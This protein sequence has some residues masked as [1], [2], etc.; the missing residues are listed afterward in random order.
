MRETL[1]IL[2]ASARAAAQSARRAG[3]AP[4]CGDLFADID[5]R[6]CAQATS[7]ADF[8]SE[9][10]AVARAAPQGAWMYTGG[11]ENYP[12]LVERIAAARPLWGNSA[13]VLRRVRDPFLTTET[14]RSAGLDV[15][16][17][18]LTAS[19]LFP[20]GVRRSPH[21][22]DEAGRPPELWL[23]KGRRSSGGNQVQF[24]RASDE[25]ASDER[26]SYY[27]KWIEGKSC[28]A[29]YIAAGGEA[30]LVGVTEQLLAGSETGEGA[31]ADGE[32]ADGRFRYAGSVGPLP[33][34]PGVRTTFE[35]IGQT[36][37]REFG[38][39]GFFGV[40]TILTGERVWP[41]EVNPRYPASA[42][43]LDRALENSA[44]GWH[45]KAC[46]ER[47][48][49]VV[50]EPAVDRWHGKRIHFARRDTVA[51][52]EFV[53]NAMICNSG[54]PWP[55]IADIPAPET[56]FHAG[57]P[58]FTVLAEG[59]NRESVLQRLAAV[60]HDFAEALSSNLP[61]RPG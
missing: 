54:R 26:R 13:S 51:S 46:R 31:A 47:E 37:A 42:E 33:L 18:R 41:V 60:E 50:P 15:P 35:R 25:K 36:L 52:P 55:T 16:E 12:A 10:E 14:L 58:V 40:D 3:F 22:Q 4:V 38:L 17:C 2:G 34:S 32:A 7:V 27:Q 11:L 24:W 56:R 30:R 53:E 6:E 57:Q 29:V 48:L 5:L 59:P 44:V 21:D 9:L 28:G 49:P 45:V 1:L 23:R 39:I 20:D 19:G 61:K 8:P 43:I